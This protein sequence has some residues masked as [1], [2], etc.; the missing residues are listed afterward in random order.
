MMGFSQ[1]FGIW[2][3]FLSL[4]IPVHYAEVAEVRVG[5]KISEALLNPSVSV[6]FVILLK[7][8]IT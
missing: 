7:L 8:E 3:V 4:L 6:E 5:K 2:K 1:F